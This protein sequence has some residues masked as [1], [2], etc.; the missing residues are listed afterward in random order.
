MAYALNCPQVT[1]DEQLVACLKNRSVQDLLN[2]KIHKPKYVPAFAPLVESAVIPDKPVNLMKN[3]ERLA[4]YT[5]IY[6][7]TFLIQNFVAETF[8]SYV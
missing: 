7:F 2:V 5:S 3:A 6:L 8:L 1:D 4:R